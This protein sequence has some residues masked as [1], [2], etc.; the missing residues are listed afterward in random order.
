ML[1]LSHR[2]EQVNATGAYLNAF[3]A[4]AQFFFFTENAAVL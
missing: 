2:A 1:H 3:I 4:L